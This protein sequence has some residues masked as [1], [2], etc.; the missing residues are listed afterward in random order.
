MKPT[1]HA[2]DFYFF[3]PKNWK[4][5]GYAEAKCDSTGERITF[6][7]G[8]QGGTVVKLQRSSNVEESRT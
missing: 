3:K 2:P 7:A 4:F 8:E 5:V 6:K 1:V